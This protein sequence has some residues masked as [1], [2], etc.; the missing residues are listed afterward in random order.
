MSDSPNL[1]THDVAYFIIELSPKEVACIDLTGCFHYR[2][3]SGDEHILVV[4][5][6][7]GNT[8]LAE[9]LKSDRLIHWMDDL[10]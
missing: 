7:D 9:P 2:S 10:E 1:K 4:Y 5:N 3:R 8:I 6:F